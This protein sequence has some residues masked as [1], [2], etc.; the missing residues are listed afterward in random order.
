MTGVAD[1]GVV[2]PIQGT[3]GPAKAIALETSSAAVPPEMEE[4]VFPMVRVWL[5]R[6]VRLLPGQSRTVL[7]SKVLSLQTQPFSWRVTQT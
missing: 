4:A 3:G 2:T 6:S 7:D 1:N 5:S